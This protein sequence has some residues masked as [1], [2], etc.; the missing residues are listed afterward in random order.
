MYSVPELQKDYKIEQNP[1][2]K[3]NMDER[4]ADMSKDITDTITNSKQYA[5]TL[6]QETNRMIKTTTQPSTSVSTKPIS[7]ESVL[8]QG[9]FVRAGTLFPKNNYKS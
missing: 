6:Q 2:V 9:G 1:I 4:L 8:A 3:K 5:K 7:V